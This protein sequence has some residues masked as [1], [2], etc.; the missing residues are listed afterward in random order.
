MD[1]FFDGELSTALARERA[2]WRALQQA[3]AYNKLLWAEWRSAI[4]CLDRL[5]QR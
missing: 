1:D 3:Q 2:A 4:A 5:R